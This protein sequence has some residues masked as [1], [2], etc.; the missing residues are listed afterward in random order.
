MPRCNE[1]LAEWAGENAQRRAIAET[2]TNIAKAGV[3]IARIVALGPLAG[4]MATKRGDHADGD[5]QKELDFLS[6][7]IVTDALRASPVAWMGSEEDEKA[8]RLN[9]GAP[10]AVNVDP[11]RRLLQHR[12]ERLDWHDLFDPAN[13][14]GSPLLQPG[15]NQLAGRLRHLWAANR[16]WC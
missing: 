11:A 1:H 6:N 14:A 3:E 4:D 13:E 16:A 2:I 7:K 8:V 10:L 9:D 5:T 15:R 12:H